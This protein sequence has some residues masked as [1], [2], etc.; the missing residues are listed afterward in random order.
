MFHINFIAI[1]R[2]CELVVHSTGE[3]YEELMLIMIGS[4][5]FWNLPKNLF[6][7]WKW[8]T[9]HEETQCTLQWPWSRRST[10]VGGDFVKQYKRL[11]DCEKHISATF[12]PEGG[13]DWSSRPWPSVCKRRSRPKLANVSNKHSILHL[14]TFG[15]WKTWREPSCLGFKSEN[16][17][18]V[19]SAF[20]SLEFILAQL[21]EKRDCRRDKK[22]GGE[23]LGWAEQRWLDVGEQAWDAVWSIRQLL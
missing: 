6:N 20:A 4:N 1:L 7:E 8:N 13:I 11:A 5:V 12:F 14:Q 3:N 2:L 9:F 22:N 15:G 21:G 19:S 17:I 16:Y 18:W 10:L 23:S